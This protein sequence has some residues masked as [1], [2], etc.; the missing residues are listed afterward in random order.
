M[1]GNTEILRFDDWLRLL[2]VF[3]QRLKISSNF[4]YDIYTFKCFYFFNIQVPE[5]LHVERIVFEDFHV[6]V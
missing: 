2:F 6:L 4:H 5:F 1:H 3:Q